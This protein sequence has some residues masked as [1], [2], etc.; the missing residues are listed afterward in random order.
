MNSVNEK[1]EIS[2]PQKRIW[3]NEILFPNTPMHNI[4]SKIH[5]GT[6]LDIHLL[7]KTINLII[8]KNDSLRLKFCEEEGKLYQYVDKYKFVNIPFLDFTIYNDNA[9]KKIKEFCMNEGVKSLYRQNELLF[10]FFIYKINNERMGVCFFIHHIIFDGMSCNLLLEQLSNIYQQLCNNEIVDSNLENSY[11][12]FIADE[13]E[14][15][16]SEEFK[17]NKQFWNQKFSNLNANSL[18]IN[19]KSIKSKTKA[20]VLNSELRDTLK[21]FLKEHNITLNKFFISISSIYMSRIFGDNDITLAAACFNRSNERQRKTIGMFTGI[22]PLRINLEDDISFNEF[23]NYLNS[24]LK[25][26]YANQKYPYDLLAQDL[27][28]RKRGVDSLFKFCV[29][30]FSFESYNVKN[31]YNMSISNEIFAQEYT[32]IPLH[33]F[34]KELKKNENIELEVQYRIE[35][36]TEEQITQMVNSMECIAKQIISDLN[37]KI[38]EIQI[39]SEKEKNLILNEFNN[40]KKEYPKNESIGKLFEKVVDASKDKIALVSKGKALTYREVNERAN[41]IAAALRKRGITRNSI[42]PILCDKNLETI[43]GMLAIVKSGGAYLAID[44]EYPKSRIDYMLEEVRSRVILGKKSSLAKFKFENYMETINYEDEEILNESTDNLEQINTID[45]LIYVMYTSG[46]TGKPKGVCIKQKNV[47]RLIKNTNFIELKENDRILQTGSIAFDASTFEVW[48]AL[49]NGTQLFVESKDVILNPELLEGYLREN[50]I[51]I[52]WFTAPLFNQLCKENINLFKPLRCLL[53]GGDVVSP[54]S[55]SKLKRAHKDLMIIDGYGPTENTTFS[56]TYAISGEWD[57]NIQ[58]PIGK[59]I[60]NSTAYIMDKNNNLLPIGVPGELCVGGDGIADGY[61]NREELTKEKFIEN[62]YVKGEKIYRTGDLAKWLPD[63]NISFMG[64]IDNQV[65]IRGFRIELQEIEAQL[66]QYSRIKEAVVVDK[67]DES[68]NKYLCAYVLSEEKVSSKEIKEFLKK[69][70]PNYMIPSYII[71]LEKFSLNCNGK[72]D[73]RALPSPDLSQ[74]DTE[75]IKARSEIEL[76]LEDIWCQIFNLKEIS[77]KDNFFD[78]GGNSLMAVNLVSKV[79]KEF[80]RRIVVT[81]VFNRPTIEEL[82][83]YLKVMSVEEAFNFNEIEKVEEKEYYEASAVQKRIYAINQID[84]NS[85]NYNI[86]IAYLI[87]GNFDNGRLDKA[88][89]E[90]INRHESLRTSFHVLDENIFQK[91]HKKVNFKVEHI[92]INSKFNEDKIKIENFIKPFDLGKAPLIHVNLIKF[93]DASILL[94]DIHHIVSDGVSISIITKELSSLYNGEKLVMPKVQYK[95]FSNWQNNL[96]RN[97]LLDGQEKY[98]LNMFK[99]EI[100]KLNMPSD[101]KEIPTE[102]FKGDILTFEMDEALTLKINQVINSLGVTKFMFYMAAYNVLLYKYTGQDDLII[103]TP[104]A[105]RTSEE[106]KDT[107]GMFVNTLPLRNKIN[108]NSSFREFLKEVKE[109][110]LKAFENQNYDLKNIIEKLNIKKVS[111]FNVVLSF[112]NINIDNLRLEDT[113]I[114]AYRLKSTMAKFPISMIL[115]EDKDK[116]SGELEYQTELYKRETIESFIKHY[117]NIIERVLE[118]LDKPIDNFDMLSKWEKNII[119]N[120][121]NNRKKTY[122]H[123]KTIK[124][125]FEEEAK[126]LQN[127]TALV[128]NGQYLAYKELNERANQLGNLLMKNGIGREDI[129]PILCDRSIDTIIGMLAIIKSGA[130]YLPIDEDYPEA[131]IRYMLEDSGSKIILIKRHQLDKVKLEK[132][133]IQLIDLNSKEIFKES[134]ENLP[135]VNSVTDLVYVIY[136][137]GSTGKP[138]GVCLENRNLVNLVSNSE[139]IGINSND[140]I[141]QS[142]SLSF[143][144]SVFQVWITLLNGAELHLEEKALIINENELEDYINKN[145][146]TTML[147]PTPLFNQYCESNIEIFKDLRCLIVGGDVLSSKQVSKITKI[148]KN[149]KIL[150]AYGPTENAVISTLYEVKG[151]WNENIAIPIGTPI[152]NSTAYIMDKNNNLLPIGTPGEL[153]VGGAGIARGYLNREELTKEKFIENPYV[154]GEKIYKTGDLVKWLPDGNI[155]FMGRMDYQVK[156]NGFRI[157]PQEIEGEL[158]K[159]SKVKEAVVVDKSDESGNKYLCAYVVSKEKVSPKEIKEFLKR[160][161]PSYMI[162]SHIMQLE[163]MPVNSN[164]KVE[165]KALP[166]PKSFDFNY[167]Y[168]M[169]KNNI[170]EKISKAWSKILGIKNISTD[171]NFFEIGGNSLKAISVVSRL[172]KEFSIAINDIF[173][174]PTIQELALNI[175]FIEEISRSEVRAAKEEVSITELE[176]GNKIPK[177]IKSDYDLYINNIKKYRNFRVNDKVTYKNIL[178]TGS[179]GYVGINILKELL[180]STDSKVYLL[181]RGK[182]IK[183]AEDRVIKKA[184]FYFGKEFYVRYKNRITILIGNI[185]EDYLGMDIDAYKK[186]SLVIDCII[187]SAA[188]VKHYGKYEGFYNINVLGTKHLLDFAEKGLMKDFNQIST[189]SVGSGRVPNKEVVMFS[190]LDIDIGQECDNVYVRSK[191]EAEKLVEEAGKK[192]L[193]TKIFRLGNVTFN[194][195]TGLFQENIK[196]NAFYKNIKAFIKLKCLP[197]IKGNIFDF[198][199]VDQLAKAIIL[200][201]DK[202]NYRNEVFHIENPKKLSAS[203]LTRALRRQYKDIELKNKEDFLAYISLKREDE[204]LREYVEDV[205]VHLGLLEN[206]DLTTFITVSDRTNAILKEFNFEWGKLDESAIKRMLDYCEKVNFL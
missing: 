50:K 198:S 31:N 47:I 8:K 166:T 168:I 130:A 14:Y 56:T 38:S 157:E 158:L 152:S 30:Y 72:I 201:F 79:H 182:D 133:N 17:K 87:K 122:A 89:Y 144:A 23:L 176:E 142:G 179:T 57:E 104:A 9:E 187:N 4:V 129:V 197:E 148:Y 68:G 141:L 140:K 33:I 105:G 113:E 76:K 204:E 149:L 170:E 3:Y 109:N 196:E 20:F 188:N 36:Y 153:C 203:D 55:V 199:Y 51:T 151:K 125:R 121:F 81:D 37:I 192:S 61:L 28:L 11:I 167:E 160:E 100:P 94:I 191:L 181:L 106:L 147:M 131:R 34:I 71:Q 74:K 26:C 150:N 82:A 99:G 175:K 12:D 54:I 183:K 119:L 90:L 92:K 96:Y 180:I 146:I 58:I 143:D 25:S 163:R 123:N 107:V 127:K 206:N 7:E 115:K 66:L 126:N 91:V 2:H 19:P 134:K 97:G 84:L 162:P 102:S 172:A 15:L 98:W 45:D 118:D 1:F 10:K 178:L 75:F 39:V 78:I 116:I 70:L 128:S 44:G 186:L 200:L 159:Y 46:S 154:S 49:L 65:K 60:A 193:N 111:L 27:E 108:K 52:C 67:N 73:K 41:Q 59:P 155:H 124:E 139:Y 88:I 21:E 189:M 164:G 35:D 165:R 63:G 32:N 42:V 5:I 174:Y 194:Y 137:S 185:S 83:E 136:T 190:E 16:S 62:P 169:P 86:P 77:I 101:Y 120:E 177:A 40:T 145:E 22:M 6:N 156:I 18:Y 93:D 184:D 13:R 205:M 53:T 64:R 114:S 110:S 117:I 173:K 112:Q 202:T 195:E 103:G 135:S 29:N 48:G 85:T 95:D 171:L 138:K 132:I 43:I 80:K 69:V 161:L 24:E